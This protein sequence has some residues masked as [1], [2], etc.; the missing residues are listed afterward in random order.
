VFK[1]KTNNDNPHKRKRE[2]VKINE[3]PLDYITKT[4]KSREEKRHNKDH[5]HH[6]SSSGSKRDRHSSRH[7]EHKDKERKDK[8]LK[9]STPTVEELRAKRLE[10][11]RNEKTRVK[12]LFLG[13]NPVQQAEEDQFEMDERNRGYN[14]QF[15]REDTFKAKERY[16]SNKRR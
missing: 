3:D 6:S 16:N 1:R 9:N 14:S 5:K 12:A 4:L 8:P 15:N 7:R 10:R 13:H 11:E 2:S